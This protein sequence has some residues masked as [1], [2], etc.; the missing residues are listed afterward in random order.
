[1]EAD[2]DHPEIPPQICGHSCYDL[3]R[4][5]NRNYI[6]DCGQTIYALLDKDGNLEIKQVN[7]KEVEILNGTSRKYSG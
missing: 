4:K 6:L 1:M 7:G 3:P 2:E 5:I